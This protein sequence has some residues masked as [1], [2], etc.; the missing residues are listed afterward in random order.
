MTGDAIEHPS[1]PCRLHVCAQVPCPARHSASKQGLK[2]PAEH[3]RFLGWLSAE[4]GASSGGAS[5]VPSSA[6]GGGPSG[7]SPSPTVATEVPSAVAEVALKQLPVVN[8]DHSDI[9]TDIPTATFRQQRVLPTDIPPATL[10]R[11]VEGS[12][13]SPVAIEEPFAYQ[14]QSPTKRRKL[15]WTQVPAGSSAVAE[16][17][18][19]VRNIATG[20]HGAAIEASVAGFSSEVHRDEW[21]EPRLWVACGGVEAVGWDMELSLIHI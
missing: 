17:Y 3:I 6:M 5:V 15:L 21:E 4:G 9:P 7:A 14:L 12:G 18:S 2:A 8:I 11:L 1:K 16:L 19:E 13:A 10:G 20:A